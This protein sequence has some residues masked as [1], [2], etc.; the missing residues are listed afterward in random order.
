[1]RHH[2]GDT[3]T[4]ASLRLGTPVDFYTAPLAVPLGSADAFVRHPDTPARLA[5]ALREGKLDIA[6]L[7]P[8]DYAR[9][10]SL[11]EIVPG[12]GASSSVSTGTVSLVFREENLHTVATVAIDPAYTSEIVLAKIVLAEEFELRPKFVPVQ[13]S[14]D[15]MLAQADAVL[16]VGDASLRA[17]DVHPNRIDLVEVWTEMTDL[18][19]VHGIW[20]AR[21]GKCTPVHANLLQDAVRT[22]VQSIET[23][24]GNAPATLFPDQNRNLLYD[25]LNAFSYELTDEDVDGFQEFIRFAYYHGV[26]PD[27]GDVNFYSP[28]SPDR[29]NDD[30]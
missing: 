3:V 22:G 25:Y 26:L 17:V 12:A 19:F 28:E 1:M 6:F 21:A 29:P 16:L 23:I 27:V 7:S 18:P 15:E 24:A 14:V 10:S 13:G 4:P 8:L 2:A 9:E 30:D 11:Y 20:V 5:L